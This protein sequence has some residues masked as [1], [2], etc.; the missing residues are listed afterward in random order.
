MAYNSD[1]NGA[2]GTYNPGFELQDE[3]P[4][5]FSGRSDLDQPRNG[6]SSSSKVGPMVT[7]EVDVDE[8]I[9]VRNGCALFGLIPLP[10]FRTCLK[11]QWILVFLCWASTVQVRNPKEKS[12]IL[13]S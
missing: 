2:Q 9:G 12:Y 5:R 1:H 4:R 8:A 10:C 3:R 11:A 7:R 6:H 13:E